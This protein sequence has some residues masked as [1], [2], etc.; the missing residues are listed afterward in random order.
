MKSL[1]HIGRERNRRRV[2]SRVMKRARVMTPAQYEALGLD[3]RAEVIQQL[4]PLGLMAAA[5]LMEQEIIMMAGPVYSR[6]DPKRRIYR[7]GMMEG[8]V[9]L[10]GQ[11][12]PIAVPRIKDEQGSIPLETYCRLHAGD[13]ADDSMFKQVLYG[14]SCRNYEQA[15]RAVP[16]AIGLSKSTVSQRF[17][18]A[19]AELL[20]AFQERPLGELDIVAVFIDG[21]TFADDQM[22]IA[23]GVSLDGHKHVLGFAQTDTEN[24]RAVRAFLRGL[25]DRGLD[26]SRGL[27]VVIDGSKGLRTAVRDAFG[28][29]AVVQRCHWHKRENIV[30]YLPA[31]EQSAMRARLQRAYDRPSYVEARQALLVI[32]RDLEG[33]NQSAMRSLDEGFEEA[34]TL[35]RLGVFAIVGQSFKTNNC[36]ESINAQAEERCSKV[37]YWKNSNHKC[38][39]LVAALIDIEPRLQQVKGNAVKS[40]HSN[41]ALH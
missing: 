5:E 33:R 19:S 30:S 2:K 17:V 9:V 7:N 10:A 24:K 35:H 31:R 40:K 11:R 27:L 4:I 29:S 15:V 39:W 38:R 26:I 21:K 14:V 37:D 12:V 28:R 22:V 8:S 1:H 20:K 23:L 32:R 3:A 16:G 36:I 13:D 18:A 41:F 6:K 34:L 25:C